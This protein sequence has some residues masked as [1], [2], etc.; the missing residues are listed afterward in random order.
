MFNSRLKLY[1]ERN[2]DKCSENREN[3]QNG[4]LLGSWRVS[5]GNRME[6]HTVLTDIRDYP[7]AQVGASL[8]LVTARPKL[9]P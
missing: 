6:G 1:K 9:R 2:T 5:E 4:E 7:V 3:D 8:F